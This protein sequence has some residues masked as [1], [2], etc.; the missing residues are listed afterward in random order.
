MPLIPCPACLSTAHREYA[1]HHGRQLVI[2]K[3]CGF[4]FVNPMPEPAELMHEV[5]E[6]QAYSALS[7]TAAAHLEE[8]AH[9]I[10]SRIERQGATKGRLLDIGCGPGVLLTVARERGW[11]PQGLELSTD[12]A[13]RCRAAGLDVVTE[14]LEKAGFVDGSFDAVVLHHV[15]EHVP[16]PNDTLRRCCLLLKSGG[17]LFVAV[18]NARSWR[19]RIQGEMNAYVYQRDHL[20]F[21]DSANLRKLVIRHLG[22][23]ASIET[24][25][26]GGRI[27][28]R[29]RRSLGGRLLQAAMEKMGLGVEI[30]C[31]AR[32]P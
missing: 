16:D 29:A 23:P 4:R 24:C 3:A 27:G 13:E 22:G 9:G 11:K 31:W 1:H 32:K 2:C 25:R 14:P 6:S 19:A 7:T 26:L 20:L 28:E 30:R 21:F 5:V 18:P 15:L 17:I 12:S 10:L 8:L